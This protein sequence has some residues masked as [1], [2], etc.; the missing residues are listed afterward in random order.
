[1][2]AANENVR[3][4]AREVEAELAVA[5]LASP[6]AE[7][8]V[9]VSHACAFP[10]REFA[11][12]LGSSVPAGALESSREFV[13]RRRE[14][15]PLQLIIGTAVF[16][17]LELEVE[18]GVFIPR[19]E[20][21]G[22]A[23]IAEGLIKDVPA[24]VVI[25]LCAG[26]GP[27]AVYLARKRPDAR[28][29]AVEADAAAAALIRRNAA[30]YDADVAVTEGDVLGAALKRRFP[31]ADLIAANPPYI[32]SSEIPALPPEVRDWDPRLA[33]DGGGDGLAYYP[34]LAD[35]ASSG[36]KRG[37]VIAMEIGEDLAEDVR[38]TFAGVGEAVVE[39]D[40]A[41]RNRYLWTR[42]G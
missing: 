29:Y 20:T 30:R 12:N 34:A 14:R 16:L 21:E 9:L 13:R 28:V 37:G 32:K 27:L 10:A 31:P 5:G 18:A 19:P 41:G 11:G 40:L 15:E 36:L 35:W 4:L 6:A 26:A 39:K 38:E 3:G 42:K 7:A 2:V 24:P 25:D 33:L 17:D 8:R 23:V 1:V 22:L